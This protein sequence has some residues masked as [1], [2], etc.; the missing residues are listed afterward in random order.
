[1]ASEY[2]FTG[3]SDSVTNDQPLNINIRISHSE[4]ISLEGIFQVSGFDNLVI[5]SD[6]NKIT[7]KLMGGVAKSND[8]SDQTELVE[9]GIL[10]FNQTNQGSRNIVIPRGDNIS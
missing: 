10:K 8:D 9:I 2:L 5:N 1:M 3:S 6:I 4:D 7:C